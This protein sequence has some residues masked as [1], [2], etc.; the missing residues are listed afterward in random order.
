MDRFKPGWVYPRPNLNPV[1]YT[2]YPWCP[3]A[4]VH[5]LTMSAG[6]LVGPLALGQ[7]NTPSPLNTASWVAFF[8]SPTLAFGGMARRLSLIWLFFFISLG[9]LGYILAVWFHTASLSSTSCDSFCLGGRTVLT[10]IPPVHTA[11]FLIRLLTAYYVKRCEDR[12]RAGQ[13]S[14]ALLEERHLGQPKTQDRPTSPFSL[15]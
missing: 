3:L 5:G 15:P 7:P 14:I 12:A 4:L 10:C 6:C 2:S 11:Y 8:L 1:G 9:Y 13:F